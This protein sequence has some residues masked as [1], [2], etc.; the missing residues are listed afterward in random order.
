MTF[1]AA[2]ANNTGMPYPAV[3]ARLRRFARWHRRPLGILAAA[4]C[5]FATIS[6]LTPDPPEARAVLAATRDLP[7]GTRLTDTDLR[8]VEVPLANVPNGALSEPA[9]ALGRTI[10]GGLTSGSI[11]TTASILNPLDPQAGSDE[12]L[13]PFRVPDTATVGLLQVGDRITVVGAT[14]DGGAIEIAPNVRV[15]ALP[16]TDSGALGGDSGALVVVAADAE[17]AARL[18]AAASQMRLAIVLG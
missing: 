13:V 16:A 12:R 4:V 10:T 7:A 15:A 17:T 6:A 18:A 2:A 11:L 14:M 9:E 8:Q 5:L 1:P 3:L